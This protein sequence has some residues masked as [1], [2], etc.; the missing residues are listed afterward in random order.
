LQHLKSKFGDLEYT[1]KYE[2]LEHALTDA[3][4]RISDQE[5]IIGLLQGLCEEYYGYCSDEMEEEFIAKM[6]H[7]QE[8][9]EMRGAGETL[10]DEN[11]RMRDRLG[12][13]IN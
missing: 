12:Y 7:G 2:S 1:L 11:M 4:N 8:V 9:R 3:M 6:M 5:R 10:K 13:M